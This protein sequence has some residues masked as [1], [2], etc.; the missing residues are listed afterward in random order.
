MCSLLDL[1][2]ATT[3]EIEKA[4]GEGPDVANRLKGRDTQYYFFPA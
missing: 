2:G 1:A 4:K 3:T